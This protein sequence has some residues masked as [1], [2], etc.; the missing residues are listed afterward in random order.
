MNIHM[1]KDY[2]TT[3]LQHLSATAP[4][5]VTHAHMEVTEPSYSTDHIGQPGLFLYTVGD[6][7]H[8]DE[9]QC[10]YEAQKLNIHT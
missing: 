7:M 9:A 2:G 1:Q 10:A 8:H 5:N 6:T 3:C 4:I